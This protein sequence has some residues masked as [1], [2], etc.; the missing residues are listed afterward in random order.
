MCTDFQ[1]HRESSE[2]F[3]I[4]MILRQAAKSTD[5]TAV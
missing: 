3:E 1:V 2:Y 5:W 4:L